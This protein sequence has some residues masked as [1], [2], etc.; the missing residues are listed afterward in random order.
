MA[1]EGMNKG[2]AFVIIV[3][4]GDPHIIGL[5]EVKPKKCNDN[6]SG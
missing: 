1:D 4:N 6:M 3:K 5:T 2:Y